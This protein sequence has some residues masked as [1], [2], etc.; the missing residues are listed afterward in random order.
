MA[1]A[2]GS[3]G[4]VSGQPGRLDGVSPEVFGGH[5]YS[6]VLA[7]TLAGGQCQCLKQ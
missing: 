7:L 6:G 3:V 1:T 5:H 4:W 2:S